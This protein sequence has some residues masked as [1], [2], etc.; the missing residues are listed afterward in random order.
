MKIISKEELVKIKEA[1]KKEGKSGSRKEAKAIIKKIIAD[2]K[3]K[4]FEITPE[5]IVP[6]FPEGFT[7]GLLEDIAEEYKVRVIPQNFIKI[8]VLRKGE[9]TEVP[10]YLSAIIEA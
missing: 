6:N 9:N 4:S 3:G 8:K 2:N 1:L 7:E 5:D 10:R